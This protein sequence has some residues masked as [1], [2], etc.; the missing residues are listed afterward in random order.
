MLAAL[1]D[2]IGQE[3]RLTLDYVSPAG[4]GTSAEV[5]PLAVSAGYL[6]A[7]TV[8]GHTIETYSLARISGVE[9]GA[10]P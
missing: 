7:L 2:A 9:A 3:R 10:S 1:R 8:P 5:V 6:T 4:V